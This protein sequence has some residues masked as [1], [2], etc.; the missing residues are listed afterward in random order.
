MPKEAQTGVVS[1]SQN[2]MQQF[3]WQRDIVGGILHH[4]VLGAPDDATTSSSSAALAAGYWRLD[5]C[6]PFIH[7]DI[8]SCL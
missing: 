5:I 3:M 8:H 6:K 7:P 1:F 2:S 4:D